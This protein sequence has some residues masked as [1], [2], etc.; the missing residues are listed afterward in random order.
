MSQTRAD[1]LQPQFN[2]MSYDI[3]GIWDQENVWTGPY[4]KGHTN[5]TE[6]EEGL[7]LLWRNGISEDKVVM[8]FGFYGRGF[9][10]SDPNCSKPPDCQFSS[11]SFP[12]DCTNEP[13]ILSYSGE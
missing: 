10:M 4:L 13:G 1:E 2:V 9:T 8:G 11:A 5:L 7:D 6:I 12:G 3:H